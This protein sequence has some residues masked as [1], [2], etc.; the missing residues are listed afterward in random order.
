MLRTFWS[1]KGGSGVTVTAAVVAGVLAARGLDTVLV[2]LC[3]DQPAVLGLPEPQGP[4]L[5]DWCATP[6]RSGTALER[7]LLPVND[8]LRL[9]PRGRDE[10]AGVNDPGR[11]ADAVA[12]LASHVVVDAGLRAGV[13]DAERIGVELAA[14]GRSHLVIRPCYLAL[15]R[16]ARQEVEADDVVLVVDVGRALDRRDVADVLGLPV[17]ATIEVDPAVARSVDSGMLIGRRHRP[18]HRAVRDLT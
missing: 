2:D 12:A 3:G 13:G 15:R 8:G 18:L 7:L 9:L 1:V 6:D 10:A 11:V 17:S 14:R 16:A 5:L 4:G